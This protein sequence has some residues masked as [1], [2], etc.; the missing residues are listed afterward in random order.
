MARSVLHGNGAH[1]QTARVSSPARQRNGEVA[2]NRFSCR[3][4]SSF[5]VRRSSFVVRRSSFVVRCSLFNVRSSTLDVRS[6]VR[7]FV[8]SS[9]V[10]SKKVPTDKLRTSIVI[11][12]PPHHHFNTTFVLSVLPFSV[13]YKAKPKLRK[14]VMPVIPRC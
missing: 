2:N 1:K 6:F 12:P 9:V 3:H 5:V 11:P 14:T 7:S 8:R 13:F 10:R 4:R